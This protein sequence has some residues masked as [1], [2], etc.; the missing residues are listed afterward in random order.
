MASKYVVR[1]MKYQARIIN[2]S[3]S[4]LNPLYTK[5]KYGY[6]SITFN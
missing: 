4:L 5:G 3:T 6:N 2:L 1:R